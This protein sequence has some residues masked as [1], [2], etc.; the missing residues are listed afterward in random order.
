MAAREE[1]SV[2]DVL[3]EYDEEMEGMAK[4]AMQQFYDRA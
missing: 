1:E 3:S 4:R 2:R